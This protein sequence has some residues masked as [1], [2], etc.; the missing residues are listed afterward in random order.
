MNEIET[1]L[2]QDRLDVAIQRRN[3]STPNSRSWQRAEA[4]MQVVR[5]RLTT[6]EGLRVADVRPT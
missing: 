3:G 5:A 2:L 4:E 6:I 1:M